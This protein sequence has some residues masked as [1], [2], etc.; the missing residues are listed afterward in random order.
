MLSKLAKTKPFL[1]AYARHPVAPL[2]VT[3]PFSFYQ[4]VDEKDDK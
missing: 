3:R 1:H 4:K 2:A